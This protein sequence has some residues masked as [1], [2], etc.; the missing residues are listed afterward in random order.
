MARINTNV[1]ALVAQANLRRA[2]SGLDTVLERLSTGLKINRGADD[3][4]GLIVSENLRSEIVN[5]NQA[6]E[7]SQRAS[8]IVATTEGAL[9]EVASLLVDI[10]EL[11]L[12][13]ANEGALSDAEIKANQL[14]IDSAIESIT[15]IANSTTFAGRTLL[16]GQL[17]Y[18][19]SGVQFADLT[20]VSVTGAKFGTRSSIP[21]EVSVTQSAQKAE[22]QFRTSAVGSRATIELRGNTGVTNLTFEAGATASGI[23]AAVNAVSDATGVEAVFINDANPA[24]GVAFRSIEYG[25]DQFVAIR[26]LG[27]DAFTVTDVDG[28]ARTDDEGRDVEATINGSLVVGEGLNV[29]FNSLTLDLELSLQE[30]FAVSAVSR[31]DIT[32]GGATFQLG[33]EI[34]SNQQEGLGVQSIA[35][36]RLGDNTVGFLSQIVTG[37]ESSLVAGEPRKAAD[38][39]SQALLQ[40]SQLRGR[41]GAFERNTL[42]TNINQ[43]QITVENLTAAESTIRDTD[44][45]EA[46]SELTRSQILVNAGTSVLALAN[47]SPQS[48]LSLLGG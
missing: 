1:P 47:A 23:I 13:A 22:L 7:N 30:D 40:V 12:E 24:S 19:T 29:Q 28:S 43:L 25:S 14:Q 32:G 18:V 2:H 38:I 27:G 21:V 11:I 39:V 42:Q 46:T 48:V 20:N 36:S 33:G 26:P 17:D 45:A 9:N 31:F 35:A 10:N 8:N 4:A 44:F 3:P 34:N 37:G 6:I 41:L 16:N 15:R 5:V